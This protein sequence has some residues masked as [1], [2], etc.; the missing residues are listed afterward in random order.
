MRPTKFDAV[1][2]ARWIVYHS[3]ARE[4]PVK[5][6]PPPPDTRAAGAQS[7]ARPWLTA[8]AILCWVVPFLAGAVW[9]LFFR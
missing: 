2:H 6:A 5:P 4:E 9:V 8:V 7:A 1:D 3:L